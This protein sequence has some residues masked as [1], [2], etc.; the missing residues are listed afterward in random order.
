MKISISVL[1]LAL[2]ACSGADG[3]TDSTSDSGQSTDSGQNTDSGETP[4]AVQLTINELLGKAAD[5]GSDWIEIHNASD[6][7]VDLSGMGLSD[8]MDDKAEVWSF[9]EGTSLAAGGFLLIWADEGDDSDGELHTDFK[10]SKDGE[11][12]WLLDSSD[13]TVDT[14]TA[15]EMAEGVSYARSSDGAGEW[16]LDETPTPGAS[17]N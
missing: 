4:D 1:S 6:S 16:A 17:N 15:P 13:N 7:A 3:N 14:V 9:P 2:M 10:I 5:D 8:S 11:T 12:L